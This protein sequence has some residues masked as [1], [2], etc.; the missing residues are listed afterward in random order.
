MVVPF[1]KVLLVDPMVTIGYCPSSLRK[2]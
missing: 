1:G 2:Y